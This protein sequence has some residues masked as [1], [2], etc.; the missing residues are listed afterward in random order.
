MKLKSSKNHLKM[1]A[2]HSFFFTMFDLFCVCAVNTFL[3]QIFCLVFSQPFLRHFFEK[4]KHFKM[5]F[6][7][8]EV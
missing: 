1:T 6:H 5:K 7:A 3:I 8:S 4:D 2:S